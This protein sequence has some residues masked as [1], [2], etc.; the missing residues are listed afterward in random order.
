MILVPSRDVSTPKSDAGIRDV[1]IPP[2]LV[3]LVKD[4]LSDHTAP[5]RDALLF[6]SAGN[7]NHHMAPATLY[8]V[9][10]PARE[11]AGRKG[12]A[13]ARPP[14]HRRDARR[15]PRGEPLTGVR[16]RAVEPLDTYWYH[17]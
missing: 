16:V 6:P 13:L 11:A 8:K 15:S 14:P 1:A 7:E 5:G 3:P 2:H 4:H 12:P 17:C 9:Y 10:Y